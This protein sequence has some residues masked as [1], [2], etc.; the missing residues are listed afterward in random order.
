MTTDTFALAR[1]LYAIAERLEALVEETQLPNARFIQIHTVGDQLHAL[2][3]GGRVW[4]Y[5]NETAG[6][7][8]GLGWFVVRDGPRF[9]Q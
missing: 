2:D 7:A 4:C 5:K 8:R 6:Q 3:H 1:S 9:D